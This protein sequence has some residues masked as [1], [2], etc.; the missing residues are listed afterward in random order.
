MQKKDWKKHMALKQTTLRLRESTLDALRRYQ[1]R[2]PFRSVASAADALI[3]EAL[4]AR[5][6][7][8]RAAMAAQQPV[9]RMIV[10]AKRAG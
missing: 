5:A 1:S 4:A 2:S 7:A 9:D 8:D 3:V 10:G 6:A